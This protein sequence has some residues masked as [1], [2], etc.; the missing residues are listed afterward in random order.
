[1]ARLTSA[2]NLPAAILD[3]EN[4]RKQEKQTAWPPS[5]EEADPSGKGLIGIM[6]DEL[7]FVD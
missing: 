5:N 3:S 4:L 2:S 7:G 1:M 6:D